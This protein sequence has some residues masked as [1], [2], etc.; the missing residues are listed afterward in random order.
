M[1]G[2]LLHVKVFGTA[3]L[4]YAAPVTPV[5]SGINSRSKISSGNTLLN[6]N[7]NMLGQK[8]NTNGLSVSNGSIRPGATKVNSTISAVSPLQSWKNDT[9]FNRKPNK[10]VKDDLKNSGEAVRNV[11]QCTLSLFLR[12]IQ[13][14]TSGDE[15][16]DVVAE[17]LGYDEETRDLIDISMTELLSE[18][19]A[20]RI[21]V[22]NLESL[23]YYACD[24]KNTA[25]ED[26]A[27]P[28]GV[29]TRLSSYVG[30]FER[31]DEG[32]Q[33]LDKKD[34]LDRLKSNLRSIAN[35]GETSFGVTVRSMKLDVLKD[36]SENEIVNKLKNRYM[37]PFSNQTLLE[38]TERY[39]SE[40]DPIKVNQ[41]HVAILDVLTTDVFGF[42]LNHFELLSMLRTHKLDGNDAEIIDRFS[43]FVEGFKSI[44][45]DRSFELRGDDGSEVALA[46]WSIMLF[47]NPET[48]KITDEERS[49]L[50]SSHYGKILK[51]DTSIANY[52]DQSRRDDDLN[53]YM[54]KIMD[55][56]VYTMTN[57]FIKED[58]YA[59]E[60]NRATKITHENADKTD[61]EYLLGKIKEN[62]NNA[63]EI[64][65]IFRGQFVLGKEL[66]DKYQLNDNTSQ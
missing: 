47:L 44:F 62:T 45:V 24:L 64:L 5:V 61:K 53:R 37:N 56:A 38:S 42:V 54:K 22:A 19:R 11:Y 12:K 13:T 50:K 8:T 3:I 39:A 21:D 25:K 15:D 66:Y 30:K 17:Y 55:S 35:N 18:E 57:S 26:F 20:G 32:V 51:P 28:N 6:P 43:T 9:F 1:S 65:R 58:D 10:S 52:H 36:P 29:R 49:D 14:W 16:V 46:M 23:F 27:D 34:L 2:F 60:S 41:C 63:L 31:P 48:A 4:P 33:R 59:W 40:S 7:Q